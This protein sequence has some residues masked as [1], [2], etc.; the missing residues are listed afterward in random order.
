MK[1]PRHFLKEFNLYFLIILFALTSCKTTE[2]RMQKNL[3]STWQE[4]FQKTFDQ[5]APIEV[6][7]VT[8]RNSKD[9]FFSCEDSQFGVE[10]NQDLKLGDLKFGICKINVPKNHIVGE[11]EFAKDKKQSEQNFFKILDSKAL[12]EK[13]FFVEA[14]KIKR[15]ALVFVH[16]F[17]VRYQEAVLRA[18]QIA[19]DLKYQGAVI[20][21]TWPAGAKEGFLADKMLNKTYADNAKNAADSILA[22][23]NF[24]L[25]LQKN[26]IKINLIVHSMG[27]Q[28]VLPALQLIS[29]SYPQKTLISNLI[30]NAPDF[31][32]GQFRKFAPNLK[33]VSDHTTLYCSQNDKA[34]IASKSFNNND[35]LGACAFIE[36]IDVINVG[37]I[38]NSTLGLGHGY[39]SS[40]PI[41]SDVFQTLL[42]IDANKRLFVAKSDS[43]GL[44]KYFLRR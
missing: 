42:G 11:I 28:V 14:K 34:M 18:A 3:H 40:R 13:D 8:N 32:I 41:L 39:Y 10:V 26:D 17:N 12:Q 15:Q 21:F 38:D 24:L 22:F 44:D 5:T 1:N 27:H 6:L 23:K 2:E 16:G 30:L 9:Q 20:L 19:Y 25:T 43:N 4:Y 29:E 37:E 35:R 36:E 31:E 33:K 7:V